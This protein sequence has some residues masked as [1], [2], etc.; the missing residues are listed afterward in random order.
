[1]IPNIHTAK[2]IPTE[3]RCSYKSYFDHISHWYYVEE[4]F[5]TLYIDNFSDLPRVDKDDFAS[6]KNA[7]A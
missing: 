7:F 3:A 6:H 4:Y 5:L 2:T 1:M